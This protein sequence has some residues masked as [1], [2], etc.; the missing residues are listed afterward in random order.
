MVIFC[1]GDLLKDPGQKCSGLA[2]YD[3]QLSIL[4]AHMR[5]LTRLSTVPCYC[6]RG[7]AGLEEARFDHVSV[8]VLDDPLHALWLDL[9]ASMQRWIA[10]AHSAG[11]CV[12]SCNC[13][14]LSV[15]SSLPPLR[16]LSISELLIHIITLSLTC[17]SS[18]E[19]FVTFCVAKSQ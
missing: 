8:G 13:S 7:A 6:I 11:L 5:I 19:I 18:K 1:A 12:Y 17:K 10:E 15:F 4:I 16:K 3:V 9:E 14:T 2:D